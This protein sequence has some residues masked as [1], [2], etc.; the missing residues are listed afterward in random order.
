MAENQHAQAGEVTY[1]SGTCG[2]KATSSS[3][4]YNSMLRKAILIYI[5]SVGL[6]GHKPEY[7]LLASGLALE[8]VIDF[9]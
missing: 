2:G 7:N 4:M 8:E 9:A 3:E 6:W 1:A 5:H